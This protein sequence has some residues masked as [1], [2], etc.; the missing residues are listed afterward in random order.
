MLT[1]LNQAISSAGAK[2]CSALESQH[3][4]VLLAKAS[5]LSTFELKKVIPTPAMFIYIAHKIAVKRLHVM[6][7]KD[8]YLMGFCLCNEE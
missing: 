2:L 1:S 8:D 5:K 6:Y 7:R 4:L 3:F